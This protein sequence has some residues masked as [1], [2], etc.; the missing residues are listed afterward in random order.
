M[1]ARGSGLVPAYTSRHASDELHGELREYIDEQA[2]AWA[3]MYSDYK[4][5][6]H[7]RCEVHG[8]DLADAIEAIWCHVITMSQR[9]RYCERAADMQ[10]ALKVWNE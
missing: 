3:L 5:S 1:H 4:E 10:H 2:L 9:E 7:L 6:A 8:E